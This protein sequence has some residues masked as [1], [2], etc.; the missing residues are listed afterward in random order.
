MGHDIISKKATI[1]CLSPT[2]PH[3]IATL[4]IGERNGLPMSIVHSLSSKGHKPPHHIQI[5][6]DPAVLP[7][8]FKTHFGANSILPDEFLGEVPYT[9][10]PN[11]FF[12]G[13]FRNELGPLGIPFALMNFKA[14]F[15]LPN[16][17][18]NGY[19][20][21]ILNY[22]YEKCFTRMDIKISPDLN[23]ALKDTIL[24]PYAIKILKTMTPEDLIELHVVTIVNDYP[25]LME[26]LL[27]ID[28]NDN[29]YNDPF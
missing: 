23:L 1:K 16:S 14:P 24:S 12:P 9:V 7:S 8:K 22:D 29:D 18:L 6:T 20:A 27:S 2:I 25:H 11:N 4:S 13:I 5:G 3:Q 10:N 21:H 15:F 28:L 17:K 19:E 26:K